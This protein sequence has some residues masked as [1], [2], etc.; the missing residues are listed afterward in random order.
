MPPSQKRVGRKNTTRK[1]TAPPI[2]SHTYSILKRAWKSICTQSVAANIQQLPLTQSQIDD[3]KSNH[4]YSSVPLEIREEIDKMNY[5]GVCSVVDLP[6]DR[7]ARIFIVEDSSRKTPPE[8]YTTYLRFIV[9]W[10]RF[11]SSIASPNCSKELCVYFLLSDAKKKIPSEH[12]AIDTIHANTAFTTSCSLKNEIFIFRREEWFKVFIHETFH[13]L[14]L[15]FS[16]MSGQIELSELSVC[17]AIAQGTDIRLYE[18]FCEMWAEIFHL[19][20]CLFSSSD[21]SRTSPFSERLFRSA[22]L[23]EQMFSIYQSNKILRL[24]GLTYSELFLTKPKK[25][26]KENTQ[27]FS[28]YVIKSFFLW[29]VDAF[30]KWCKKWCDSG[31][32]AP[33]QFRNEH[34]AEYCTFVEKM[35]LSESYRRITATAT[36]TKTAIA[37]KTA[38]ATKKICVKL[39]KDTCINS[40]KRT[41]RM[42]SIDPS[43]I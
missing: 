24:A 4:M 36:S 23:K 19:M 16:N 13:C 21:A 17:N 8:K 9:M 40:N 39:R 12:E 30:V 29:N 31:S 35:S 2:S 18:T 26:Y 5:V 33:I 25:V 37:T 34:V 43:W 32:A 6:H 20:F 11:A 10:L 38:S 41:L 3:I 22:L 1:S 42:T 15:D 7:K 27:A 28:Y 14:G